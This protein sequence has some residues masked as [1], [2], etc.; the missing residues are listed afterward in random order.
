MNQIYKYRTMNNNKNIFSEKN[1]VKA[2]LD[3]K[4]DDVVERYLEWL[5]EKYDRNVPVN[6][7]KRDFVLFSNS[8]I[9]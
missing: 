6:A 7:V 9:N 5:H 2:I 1:I 3:D 4:P 8:N